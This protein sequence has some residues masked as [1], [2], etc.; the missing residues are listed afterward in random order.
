MQN[1]RQ[2]YFEKYDEVMKFFCVEFHQHL[3]SFVDYFH[4]FYTPTLYHG[5]TKAQC[6]CD[7][8]FVFMAIKH[9][10]MN[11]LVL[12]QLVINE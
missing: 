4:I 12:Q 11:V 2:R 1:T 8:C 5:K 7:P 6:S 10:I 3:F 9:V